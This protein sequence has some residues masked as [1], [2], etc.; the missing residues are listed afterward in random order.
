MSL[1]MEAQLA[2]RRLEIGDGAT[3]DAESRFDQLF[4]EHF[5]AML[6]YAL[7]RVDRR[8]D[9]ADVAADIMLVAW[10]RLDDVPPGDEARLWLYGVARGVMRNHARSRNRRTRL[11]ARLCEHVAALESPATDLAAGHESRDQLRRAMEQLSDGDRELLRLSA[12]EALGTSEIASVLGVR[13]N[14]ARK[15]LE[16]ARARL[17]ERLEEDE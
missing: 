13:P 15:R 9:A 2:A 11:S 7:R 10:R 8:E 5:P 6:G 14:T 16:R 3:L 1:S 12:W 17:A 4:R